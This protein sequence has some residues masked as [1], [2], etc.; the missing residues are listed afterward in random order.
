MFLLR[1]RGFPLFVLLST[2]FFRTIA[3]SF[4]FFGSSELSLSLLSEELLDELL[5]E[6]SL[7][8]LEEKR[9]LLPDLDDST[10]GSLDISEPDWS[11]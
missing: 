1:L 8:S 10:V 11:K 9:F 4:F 5:E 7:D 3:L 6:V 2:F